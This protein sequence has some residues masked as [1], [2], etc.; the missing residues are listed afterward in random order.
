MKRLAAIRNASCAVRP[1]STYLLAPIYDLEARR[2]QTLRF[3]SLVQVNGSEN[4]VSYCTY[5]KG[6]LMVLLRTSLRETQ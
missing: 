3:P 6:C 1:W 2:E 4:E 5:A